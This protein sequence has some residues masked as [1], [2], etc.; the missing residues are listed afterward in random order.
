MCE[1]GQLVRTWQMHTEEQDLGNN[2]MQVPR[3]VL[4]Y[5]RIGITTDAEMLSSQGSSGNADLM[6]ATV[7]KVVPRWIEFR[8]LPPRSSLTISAVPYE[9]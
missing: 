3:Q 6:F 5:D 7:D 1:S 8:L 2:A 9:G 4:G